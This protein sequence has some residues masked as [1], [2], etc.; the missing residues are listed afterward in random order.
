MIFISAA[1]YSKTRLINSFPTTPDWLEQDTWFRAG[2]LYLNRYQRCSHL[3]HYVL[4][5]PTNHVGLYCVYEY[6]SC[7]SSAAN[8]VLY[9][10]MAMMIYTDV[11]LRMSIMMPLMRQ[12]HCETERIQNGFFFIYLISINTCLS[13]VSF[14][15]FQL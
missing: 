1:N 13:N 10:V 11:P 15:I 4:E 7:H 8:K 3:I 12:I 14:K 6:L 2:P 9:H 5:F